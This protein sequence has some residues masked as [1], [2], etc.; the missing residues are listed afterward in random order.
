M[1]KDRLIKHKSMI[2]SKTYTEDK[3]YVYDIAQPEDVL[4]V[5]FER[6]KNF[7]G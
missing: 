6:E 5:I 4:K 2:H 1:N 7:Q 3:S